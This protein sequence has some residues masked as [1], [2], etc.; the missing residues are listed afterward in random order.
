MIFLLWMYG[1]IFSYLS[2]LL[3]GLTRLL[4]TVGDWYIVG[5]RGIY[6]ERVIWSKM[7]AWWLSI[8][9]WQ[10][11][12]VL[13]IN[14]L[15]NS[16]VLVGIFSIILFYYNMNQKLIKLWTCMDQ[17]IKLI[18]QACYNNRTEKSPPLTCNLCMHYA[19][20]PKS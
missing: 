7:C 3:R 2:E 14:F 17:L 10:I 12:I 1:V 16:C 6:Y 20:L 4:C 11:S 15:I 9:S 13:L 18:N 5:E 19:L 8:V